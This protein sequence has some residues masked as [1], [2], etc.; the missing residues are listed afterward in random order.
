MEG[1]VGGGLV[2]TNLESETLVL[3]GD[4]ATVLDYQLVELLIT[5]TVGN[6]EYYNEKCLTY[7]LGVIG[8]FI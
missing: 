1:Q 8:I 7:T 3:V 6:V 2:R 5:V 4:A